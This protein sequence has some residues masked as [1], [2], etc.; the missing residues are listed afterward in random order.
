MK[1]TTRQ[2]SYSG[3]SARWNFPPLVTFESKAIVILPTFSRESAVEDQPISGFSHLLS[4]SNSMRH[5]EF[6]STFPRKEGTGRKKR[7]GR[8]EEKR[9]VVPN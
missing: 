9:K 7:R 4:V 3:V 1:K 8:E 5:I 2:I 6:P